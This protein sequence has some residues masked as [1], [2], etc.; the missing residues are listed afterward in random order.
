MICFDT[1]IL[2]WGVQGVARTGQEEMIDRTRRYILFLREQNEQIM[3]PTPALAE[4]FQGFDTEDRKNQLSILERSFIIPAFDLPAAY[5]A[6]GLARKAAGVPHGE[7]P[8]QTVKTDLQ[9]IA[10]AIHHGATKIITHERAHFE[11]LADGRIEV[12]EVPNIHHQEK[13]SYDT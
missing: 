2:I 3:V 11:K 10:T 1:T 7:I 6:A 5:L 12:S 4:Y 13:L 9:I 8:K